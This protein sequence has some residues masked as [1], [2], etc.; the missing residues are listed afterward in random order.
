MNTVRGVLFV[1]LGFSSKSELF[2]SYGDVTITD[3]G[4]QVIDLCSALMTH[5]LHNVHLNGSKCH[6][7]EYLSS[8]FV[9]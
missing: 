6:P 9:S 5:K 3:E 2:H 1:C 8:A 7:S 4:L